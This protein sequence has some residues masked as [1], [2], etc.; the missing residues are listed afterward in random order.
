[1]QED[2]P[3]ED[4]HEAAAQHAS[5]LQALRRQLQERDEHIRQQGEELSALQERLVLQPE[6]IMLENVN[7]C[8]KSEGVRAPTCRS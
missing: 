5:E 8:C 6:W 3:Q 4:A 2:S 1:M 7:G